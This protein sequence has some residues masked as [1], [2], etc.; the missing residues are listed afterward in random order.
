M[1]TPQQPLSAITYLNILAVEGEKKIIPLTSSYETFRQGCSLGVD[2]TPSSKMPHC[3]SNNHTGRQRPS[4]K[5]P[6]CE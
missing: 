4:S 6:G 2:A 3:F 1:T 5:L